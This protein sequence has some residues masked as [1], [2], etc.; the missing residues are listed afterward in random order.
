MPP[1]AAADAAPADQWPPD[2]HPRTVEGMHMVECGDYGVLPLSE[3]RAL[4][5]FM[6]TSSSRPAWAK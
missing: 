1:A 6:T 4:L 2:W 5:F 3:A